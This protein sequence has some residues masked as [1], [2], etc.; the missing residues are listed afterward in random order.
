MITSP[1]TAGTLISSPSRDPSVVNTT[2]TTA[3]GEPPVVRGVYGDLVLFH[4]V[5][6]PGEGRQEDGLGRPV[7]SVGHEVFEDEA[8]RHLHQA[9]VH[10]VPN[11]RGV[12]RRGLHHRG[13]EEREDQEEGRH[14]ETP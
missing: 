6:R 10:R 12:R 2:A 14:V 3:V 9:P 13:R 4:R 5:Q 8:R 7:E 11:R 1:Y